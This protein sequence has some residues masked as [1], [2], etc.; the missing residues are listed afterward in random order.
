MITGR[1]A[2]E[3]ADKFGWEPLVIMHSSY[4]EYHARK[5]KNPVTAIDREHEQQQIFAKAK[6]AFAIGP[7]LTTRL[8]DMAS[9][10]IIINPGLD[11]RD[12]HI[13]KSRLRVV[14][15]G[16]LGQEDDTIKQ[17]RLSCAGFGAAIKACNK[18]PGFTETD[19]FNRAE[20]KLVGAD[21]TEKEF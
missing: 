3:L 9:N 10:P 6:Y 18:S 17:V 11:S 16:R 7:F 4:S 20:L 21:L 19:F 1:Q 5:S 2:L 13:P 15:H 14:I 8:R 12:V